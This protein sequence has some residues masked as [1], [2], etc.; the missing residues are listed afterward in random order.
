MK[1]ITRA[2]GPTDTQP[3]DSTTSGSRLYKRV[4][5]TMIKEMQ[6]GAY[7]IGDRMPAERDIAVKL[8]VSRPVVREAMLAMEVLGLVEAR[9]GA[10]TF[11]L[12]LPGENDEPSFTVSPFELIEARLLFEGEAAAL[13]AQHITDEEL[14]R[15][16]TL[17]SAMQRENA[18]EGDEE[19]ADKLF[20]MTIAGASRNAAVARTIEQLWELRSSSSECRLLLEKARTAN[21]KPVVE[22]HAAIV[23]ALK[24]R[25]PV[26]AR[27]AMHAHLRAVLDHLLFALEEDAIAAARQS[28]AA[29]RARYQHG[30]KRQ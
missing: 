4:A 21:V 25:E 20:H 3:S 22:E 30:V 12:R 6:S 28:I 19:D 27:N 2:N 1:D 10:G 29:T 23:L 9:L 13:A 14:Q 16:E 18:K 8:G 7:S 11:V 17:I 5:H 24:S 26:A 15:L